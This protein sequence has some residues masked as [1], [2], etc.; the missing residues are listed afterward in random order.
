[1]VNFDQSI[2]KLVCPLC[3]GLFPC[4]SSLRK[5]VLKDH[6]PNQNQVLCRFGNCRMKF[7]DRADAS[8]HLLRAHNSARDD[9][10]LK[11]LPLHLGDFFK[12]RCADDDSAVA[13]VATE[14]WAKNAGDD[15]AGADDRLDEACFSIG[16]NADGSFREE[17][18]IP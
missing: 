12:A 1:M 16:E 18:F 15:R 5:H 6:E 8:T 3:E 13:T 14:D 7:K 10:Y 4:Y 9:K 17:L 2:K 11:T